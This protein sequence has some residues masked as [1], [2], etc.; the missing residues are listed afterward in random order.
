M[1]EN[2]DGSLRQFTA[3][4]ITAMEIETFDVRGGGHPTET[5]RP[6]EN[7]MTRTFFVKWSER[8]N[9]VALCLGD[10][11]TW[12][13]ETAPSSGV[14]VKKISRQLPEPKY[15]RHPDLEQI[16]ATR[17]EY[18]RGHGAGQDDGD[19]FPEYDKAEVQVFYEHAP[20]IVR[21]DASLPSE[22]SR[23]VYL[24]DSTETD[25]EAFTMPSGA[26]KYVT[27]GGTGVHGTPVPF[28]FSVVRPVE[29]FTIWWDWVPWDV[30]S[31]DGALYKRL[32]FGQDGGG[33]TPDGIP[34][35][36]TVNSE[37]LEIASAGQYYDPGQLLLEGVQ[38]IK[39]RSPLAGTSTAGWRWKI[40]FKYA[41]TPRGWLD[42]IYFDAGTPANSGYY[43]VSNNG[44]YYAVD[45][46]PDK[47]GLYNV[48]DHTKL[49]DPN[50]D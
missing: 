5:R 46:M 6:N 41:F 39:L 34:F 13:E 9:F 26:M 24:G 43:R 45:A 30:C 44:T 37:V 22:R 21:S 28:N 27:S 16:I 1:P 35:V 40:G 49:F 23:Y 3:G 31:T 18:I 36:G 20:Y 7:T 50:Y 15:G 32:Y 29:R 11:K 4:E 10:S 48:R 12:D 33:G 17:I 47:V 38:R 8:Y 2:T 42:L 19:Q 25:V 14:F